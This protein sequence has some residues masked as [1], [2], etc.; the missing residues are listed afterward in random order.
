MYDI[1]CGKEEINVFRL[2]KKKVCLKKIQ[3]KTLKVMDMVLA[4][5]CPFFPSLPFVWGFGKEKWVLSRKKCHSKE[6]FRQFLSK[7]DSKILQFD[8]IN[9]KISQMT[10]ISCSKVV[11]FLLLQNYGRLEPPSTPMGTSLPA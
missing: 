1:E 9:I 4:G 5:A 7:I 11:G 6:F 10:H 3:E 8:P 2:K